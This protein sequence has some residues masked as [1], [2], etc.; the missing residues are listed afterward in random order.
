M[1]KLIEKLDL[2][3]QLLSKR[4]SPSASFF[5]KLKEKLTNEISKGE[6]LDSLIKSYAITQYANFSR[7]EEDLLNEVIDLAREIKSRI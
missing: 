3:I 7:A 2:L 5:E 1:L 6:N 4:Q